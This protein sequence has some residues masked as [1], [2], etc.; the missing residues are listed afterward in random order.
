M[1]PTIS[2]ICLPVVL[3]SQRRPVGLSHPVANV[4]AALAL[5][6]AALPTHVPD[7][8]MTHSPK[9]LAAL[10]ASIALPATALAGPVVISQI[11]GAG[12]NV[13]ASYNGD[14]VELF[15]AGNAGVSLG[16][17]SVQ[18]ASATGTG[19]FGAN[20]VV[21]LPAVTLLPGQY[22]L[23]RQATG[24]NGLPL[25]S[26]DAL[27]TV[28]MA[29]TAGKVAL[30]NST[31]GLA[32]NGGSTPCSGAQQALILDLVGYGTAN[33]FEG[34]AAPAPSATNAIFRAAGGCTDTNSN[35]ADFTAAAALP[36]NT[37]NPLNSCGGAPVNAPIV[38]NCP[39]TLTVDQGLGGSVVLSA[40]DSDSVVN[41][42]LITSAPVAGIT[43]GSVTA[44]GADGGVASVALQVAGSVVAG[45]HPV[46]V[47][48][49]N[50]EA[51]NATCSVNVSVGATTPIPQIQ[52]SGATSPL[53]GETV[54][55][56]GIVTR[57][58]NNGFYL[59]DEAGDGD[60]AT[61]DGILVFTNSAPTVAVGDRVRASGTVAEFAPAG[62]PAGYR[63]VTEIIGL[64]ISV[65]GTG[66]SIAPTVITLPEATEGDLERY[67]GMLVT[68]DT[69]LTASQNFFQ[70][71]YGQV[72]LAAGGRLIK[73]TDAHPAGSPEAIA[74]ADAN[75]RHR[76][77]LDDGTSIQNPNPTPY[78]GADNTLR[79]GDTLP[80]ITGVIDYG[81]ATNNNGGISDYKIHPTQ[82]VVFSRDNP[83]TAAP[84][85][86]G[87]NVRVGSFNVLNYFTTFTDGSTASGLG[88]QGCS[89]DGAVAAANCR[90]AG[91]AVEFSRQRNK[92]IP[93][94]AALGAD[95]VGLMEIQNNGNAAVQNLVDGLN[96]LQ[97]AGTWA[98]IALPAEGTGTDAIRVA[99]IYKPATLTPVGAAVS[100]T[101]PI[102]NRPPLA[103]AFA[104]AGGEKV[105][106]IVNHFKSKGS[107]PVLGDPNADQGDSQGC[108]NT[109]RVEQAQALRAFAGARAAAVG[110]NDILVI[111]D[112]N[113][114]GKEDPVLDLT[115]N[116]FIDQ[117]ERFETQPYSYVFDG[118]SG[119]LDHALASVSLSAQVVGAAH[120]H[121]NAD[122]P[123]VIDYNLEFKQ[124]A[125]PTCGPDYYSATPY[126]SSDHDPVL[127]GLALIH[128]IDGTAGR[129][130]L[131]GTPG[132]DRITAGA[133]SDTL[134][135][136]G[137]RDV[138]V[139]TSLRDANDTITDF[140]P[141]DDRLDLTQLLAS[142]GHAGSNALANGVVRL[143]NV[144]G[145]VSLQIDSDGSA[146]PA[147]ARPLVTLRGLTA[148]QIDASRDLGL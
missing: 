40:T 87:G 19:N 133:G 53:V 76:I 38:P 70:G 65:L 124:P 12:G 46:T 14:Y 4:A 2:T 113:A 58:L 17:L 122:E 49:D 131:V 105:T 22:F 10:I 77:L 90:G 132:D 8:A 62:A 111:G 16:G 36:R 100:D 18:Y 34:A 67:E 3:S 35:S 32:C 121:I 86:V 114:Y 135:G 24:A 94:I 101:D 25:P 137:G 5:S 99:M 31:S 54:R 136:N 61:S 144:A 102:H 143:V 48:F 43:L 37:A 45:N 147:V 28:A 33:F 73:P 126:R 41:A 55:A 71:R 63:P 26:G 88:G 27:G 108:W 52:G 91:N 20:A 59:Q 69:P 57:L 98:T 97:G 96:A 64:N 116:G 47:R 85:A 60:P 120:W 106:V 92:I 51:Q 125:C 11:Y 123:S 81:P 1:A 42:V 110:D 129:D 140:L 7:A 9:L 74:L 93:A 21:V 72:T 128:R 109:L 112:L 107:C 30:V 83:R 68:I 66:F 146:G 115:G 134:T 141:G 84:P 15:N 44:A 145:G 29:A 82:P 89:L 13:G 95:V 139:Y 127:V 80:G 75:A 118:E 79:A 119:R 103:Q 23:V 148:A 117:S 104:N 56:I 50:N 130:T 39:T 142:I 138:F 6:R 78:F